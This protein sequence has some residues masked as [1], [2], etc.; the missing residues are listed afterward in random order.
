MCRFKKINV[1]F[2]MNQKI[3]ERLEDPDVRRE[4]GLLPRRL[5]PS[6]LELRIAP[7]KGLVWDP[8]HQTLYN[9]SIKGQHTI[10]K[11]FTL[12][13][14]LDGLHIFN[15]YERP[16]TACTYWDDGSFLVSP[17]TNPW[18]TE[19]DIRTVTFSDSETP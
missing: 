15:M 12:D 3:I 6:R 18:A 7:H 9:F 2:F 10:M 14:S 13:L 11:P 1:C 8:E 19:L 17:R 5:H 16:Y 4:L